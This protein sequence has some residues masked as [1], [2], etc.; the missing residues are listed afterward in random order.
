MY[1]P[2]RY[3]RKS[4]LK[5]FGACIAEDHYSYSVPKW[6]CADKILGEDELWRL[7][8]RR[9]RLLRMTAMFKGIIRYDGICTG[10]RQPYR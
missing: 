3:L 9:L 1:L 10:Y 8:R 7:R 2:C 4:V 5:T 6:L